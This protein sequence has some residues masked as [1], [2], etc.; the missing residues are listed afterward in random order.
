MSVDED[1]YESFNKEKCF[2]S[3]Y[4]G[5]DIKKI[6]IDC[7]HPCGEHVIFINGVYNGYLDNDFYLFMECGLDHL[8][9][10]K[11]WKDGVGE[12]ATYSED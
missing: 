6:V 12:W 1:V 7:N 3:K 2:I 11:G 4:L 8:Y 9:K 10:Y 5:V